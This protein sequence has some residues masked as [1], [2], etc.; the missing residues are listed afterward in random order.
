MLCQVQL[1][2]VGH[3]KNYGRRH[4]QFTPHQLDSVRSATPSHLARADG[5][6]DCMVSV[7]LARQASVSRQS[8]IEG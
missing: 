1:N 6:L 5:V 7:C 3:R 4:N 8:L 2:V